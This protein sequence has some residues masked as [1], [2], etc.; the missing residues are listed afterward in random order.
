M[1]DVIEKTVASAESNSNIG[2]GV[3]VCYHT[4]LSCDPH[5]TSCHTHLAC[6]PH[7]TSCHTHLA[8]DPHVTS[9][10]THLACVPHVTFCRVSLHC[11]HMSSHLTRS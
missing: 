8:C 4:H 1:Y 6:D 9:C 3:L 7:M 2:Q 5:V 11:S 10:H